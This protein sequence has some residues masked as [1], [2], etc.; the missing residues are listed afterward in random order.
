MLVGISLVGLRCRRGRDRCRCS[1]PARSLPDICYP[2]CDGSILARQRL[3]ALETLDRGTRIAKIHV[4]HDAQVA[5]CR[6]IVRIHRQC[7]IIGI[8]CGR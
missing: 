6:R 3:V 8:N 1:C 5:M 2:A 7:A 4:L